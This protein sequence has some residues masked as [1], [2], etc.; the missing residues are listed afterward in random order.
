MTEAATAMEEKAKV[1]DSLREALSIALPEGKKGLNDDGNEEDITTIE[2]KMT[3]FRD[4]LNSDK[5]KKNSIQ[6]CSYRW[7]NIGNNYLPTP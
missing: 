3:N 6:K 2:K 1:F 4:S 5:T 7:T